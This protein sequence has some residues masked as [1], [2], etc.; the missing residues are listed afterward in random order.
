MDTA[1][2]RYAHA[3]QAM[4]DDA[5]AKCGMHPILLKGNLRKQAANMIGRELMESLNVYHVQPFKD[6]LRIEFISLMESYMKRLMKDE[7][8]GFPR[9]TINEKE[10]LE[11]LEEPG[12]NRKSLDKLCD[13]LDSH[14]TI[15]F[16]RYSDHRDYS[17]LF[18]PHKMR[19]FAKL[20]LLSQHDDLKLMPQNCS[21]C[22]LKVVGKNELLPE[23][24]RPE[25]FIIVPLSFGREQERLLRKALEEPEMLKT[26]RLVKKNQ[27][28]YL[29]IN[30]AVEPEQTCEIRSYAG[31]SVMNDG[32]MVYSVCG[33]NGDLLH[34]GELSCGDGHS[35][36]P[37]GRDRLHILANSIVEIC[38]RYGA[39]AVFET[40][41]RYNALADILDYKL[42]LKGLP[43]PVRVSPFG[44]WQTCPRCGYNSKRNSV[45][46]GIF[47]CSACG[48][49]TERKLLPSLN[50]AR[51]LIRY[52]TGKVCFTCKKDPYGNDIIINPLL[53]IQ[54]PVGPGGNLEKFF[55][56]IEAKTN[57]IK[58]LLY[59]RDTE[60]TKREKKL[61][62][63]WNKL[64]SAEDV[65]DVIEIE[66]A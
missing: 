64:L 62:S 55:H 39:Q 41:P 53:G 1:M 7:N 51:R 15:Y 33:L 45:M 43:K 18:D 60:W 23:S 42:L 12:L 10:I 28:Y 57:H 47:L 21:G 27:E 25:R 17:L 65:R 3:L 66:M 48:F 20:Y 26:A 58:E 5:E 34:Q 63:L 31:F 54:Y 24:R 4:L 38:R 2:E 40:Y 35:P 19:F 32:R 14:K 13:K 37:C 59:D 50:L 22:V 9:I 46:D 8:A 61:F 52:H 49:G 6:S 36:M 16:C 11:K 30:I 44:L 56:F 29:T